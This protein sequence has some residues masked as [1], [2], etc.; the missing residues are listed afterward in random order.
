MVADDQIK[1]RLK[2]LKKGRSIYTPLKYFR[3][4]KTLAQ[5]DQRFKRIVMGVNRKNYYK[6]FKTDKGIKTRKSSYTSKFYKKYPGAVTLAQKARATGVPLSVI[7]LVYN[8]GLAAWRTG[9]RPGATGQQWGYARVHS[10][11]V[12]GKTARTADKSLAD[13][14]CKAKPHLDLCKMLR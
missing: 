14:V 9:H 7:R 4:L 12:G 13:K 10:F 2:K 1:A 8:K 3:G 11:L 6:P 5:V